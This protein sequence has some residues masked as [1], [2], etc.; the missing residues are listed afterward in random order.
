MK[1]L[2]LLVFTFLSLIVLPSLVIAASGSITVSGA[3]KVVVGNKVTLT[4]TLSSSSA[5]GS[6][7]MSLDYNK[8]YLQLTS[9]SAEAGGVK[10][11]GYATGANGTKKK[12]YTFTFKALK[13]GST[14]VS[15]D[16]YDVYANDFSSMS[17][18]SNSKTLK[19]ITQEELEASYSK[20]ND[21]KDLKVEGFEISPAFT[22]DTL[23]YSVTVP[24]G[25]TSVNVIATPN[26]SKS[27]VSGAGSV[28]VSEGTNNIN[29]V[30]RAE[31]GS[32]KTYNLVVDVIDA[33]PINVKV[34]EDNYTVIKLRSNYPCPELFTESEVLINGIEVPSCYNEKTNYT[35]VGLKKEDGTALSFIYDNGKY[36]KYNEVTGTSLKIVI[37][38]YDK[39]IPGLTKVTSMIDGKSYA[40]STY[41][42]NK[43]Y[44]VVY[45]LNIATGEKDF[46][47]YDAI[48]KT[49]SLY[50]NEQVKA[51]INTNKI[52]LYVIIVFGLGLFLSLICI[53]KLNSQKKKKKEE[54]KDKKVNEKENKEVKNKTKSKKDDQK[55]I[56]KE[57]KKEEKTKE[58]DVNEIK[59]LSEDNGED[60]TETYYLFESD[61]RKKHKKNK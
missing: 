55:E 53:V 23:N 17:I 5:I 19:I 43:D 36:T 30:V 61:R 60:E 29:I 35:L 46:Y 50:N 27:S 54:D 48:N 49:F 57:E 39:E 14:K 4:V 3:D 42:N 16:M 7:E 20:D 44:Y 47:L 58:V 18:N 26:D 37:L 21:L 51:L 28:E 13:T 41:Q 38:E 1:K 2:K 32:E 33:N 12:T 59:D 24:E 11:A 34:G 40:A 25:T 45:G 52:Y 22:K 8:S 9:S 56:K 15:V 10:M 31:N 6:W